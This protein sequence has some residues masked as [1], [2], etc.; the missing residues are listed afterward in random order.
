MT[1]A[2][3]DT[4]YEVLSNSRRR[5]VLSALREHDEPVSMTTLAAGIGAQEAGVGPE[6]V[7]TGERKRI[8]VSLYQ[9]HVPKLEAAG[10]AEYDAS[11][12]TVSQTAAT[13]D[14]DEY[15]RT[16]QPSRRWGRLNGAVSVVAVSLF[17]GWTIDAPVLMTLSPT[18]LL[19]GVVLTLLS[20]TVVQFADKRHRRNSRPPELRFR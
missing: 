18:A 19:V 20:V 16:V 8:Y 15:L 10:L 3:V 14:I 7:S 17:V 2:P 9:T 6:A 4:V 11:A 5:F 1:Q 12:G 13:T